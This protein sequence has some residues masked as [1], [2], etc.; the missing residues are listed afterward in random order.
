[1][2]DCLWRFILSSYLVEFV[3]IA[4]EWPSVCCHIRRHSSILSNKETVSIDKGRRE[5]DQM[6]DLDLAGHFHYSWIFRQFA[7]LYVRAV[8]QPRKITQCYCVSHLMYAKVNNQCVAYVSSQG[9]FVWL[10]SKFAKSNR[11]LHEK[12]M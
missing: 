2:D 5:V 11:K 4:V 6:A 7:S 3:L 10:V 9:L 8:H 1:M 12:I